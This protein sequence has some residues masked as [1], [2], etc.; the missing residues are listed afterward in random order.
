[1]ETETDKSE[2]ITAIRD[3]MAHPVTLHIWDRFKV[4]ASD[5]DRTCHV[6]LS[7]GN[8]QEAANWNAYCDALREV[9]ELPEAIISET[10]E[11]AK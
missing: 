9:I 8:F 7:K 11:E 4:M 5:G 10:R 6:M 2:S 3:W 1:V